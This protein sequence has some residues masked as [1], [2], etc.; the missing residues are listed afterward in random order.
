[1]PGFVVSIRPSLSLRATQPPLDSSKKYIQNYILRLIREWRVHIKVKVTVTLEVTVTFVSLDWIATPAL[2]RLKPHG[3]R[4]SNP[5]QKLARFGNMA[6]QNHSYG[7]SR[8]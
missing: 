4:E 8:V 3:A 1:M 6:K 2:V 7:G 5:V